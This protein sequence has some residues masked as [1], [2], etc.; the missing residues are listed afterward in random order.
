MR[1]F[2][3]VLVVASFTSCSE[4][5]VDQFDCVKVNSKQ[6]LTCADGRCVVKTTLPTLPS[7]GGGGPDA[8]RD[9]GTSP[10]GGAPDG[11]VVP[12]VYVARL[13]GGQ[14][15]PAVQTQA[16]GAGQFTLSVTDAGT[17]LAWAIS[18]TGVAPTGA[19]LMLGAVSARN[20]QTLAVLTDGGVT[21]PIIGSAPITRAQ[22]QAIS[23]YRAALIVS[24]AANPGGE[25]R[26]QLLAPGLLAAPIVF[27]RVSNGQFGGG[28]HFLLQFPP[29]A[30]AG[31]F[32]LPTAG[33]YD[34]DWTESGR[35]VE[36]TVNRGPVEAGGATLLT[37]SLTPS[38]TGALGSFE[39]LALLL[40][41][42]DAGV[43]VSG[44]GADGGVAF[45]GAF[46]LSLR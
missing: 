32:A 11:P 26:G 25:L 28:G 8:G 22:A 29:D 3:V 5:C 33:S 9:A 6:T 44:R 24:S 42:S 23:A 20:T 34:L 43:S 2:L 4:E 12:G 17:S 27:T 10:D 1:G 13:T 31:G 7:F 35:V 41:L 37:L 14:L 39:P 46:N 18:V 19:A 30:G 40:G 15:V 16:S 36:A 38:R 21:S 45:T